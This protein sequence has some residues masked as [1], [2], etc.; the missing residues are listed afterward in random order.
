MDGVLCNARA[1]IAV[2]NNST[3]TPTSFNRL[4][5]GEASV[6]EQRKACDQFM[7]D[8]H[9]KASFRLFSTQHALA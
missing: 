8:S 7:A 2:G 1:C 5:V 6:Y 4:H 3:T 9:N